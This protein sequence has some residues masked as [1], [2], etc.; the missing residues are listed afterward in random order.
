MQ[1]PTKHVN[2]LAYHHPA[3]SN[4]GYDAHDGT[5]QWKWECQRSKDGLVSQNHDRAVARTCSGGRGR[6]PVGGALVGPRQTIACNLALSVA[7]IHAHGIRKVLQQARGPLH[8]DDAHYAQA[9]QRAHGHCQLD[10]LSHVVGLHHAL[11]HEHSYD[12]EQHVDCRPGNLHMPTPQSG[13]FTR[14]RFLK[15]ALKEWN[16]ACICQPRGIERFHAC[17]HLHLCSL[18]SRGSLQSLGNQ[19]Q[20]HQNNDARHDQDSTP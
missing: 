1:L 13:I 2:I 11:E 5:N 20:H 10:G 12:G 17:H 9:V 6:Q 15:R 19:S 8:H 16:G 7:G 4:C 3:I 18:L 14:V